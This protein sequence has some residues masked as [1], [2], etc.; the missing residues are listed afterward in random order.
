MA[1]W[2]DRLNGIKLVADIVKVGSEIYEAVVIRRSDRVEL[3]EK[4][5]A[6]RELEIQLAELKMGDLERQIAE[7]KDKYEPEPGKNRL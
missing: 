1:G 7:L 2:F 4:D 6:I 3:D 5:Q